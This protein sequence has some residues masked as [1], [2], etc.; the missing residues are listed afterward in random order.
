MEK[1][2][3]VNYGNSLLLDMLPLL[4]IPSWVHYDNPLQKVWLLEKLLFL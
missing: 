2:K 4:L 3:D 1:P